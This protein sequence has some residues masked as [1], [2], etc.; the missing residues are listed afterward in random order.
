MYI[1]FSADVTVDE[2][3]ELLDELIVLEEL[4]E[5]EA[6][7]ELDELVVLEELVF[8][9]TNVLL[10][11]NWLSI[12]FNKSVAFKVLLEELLLEL[13]LEEL[14][15]E[16]LLE[17]LLSPSSSSSISISARGAPTLIFSERVLYPNDFTTI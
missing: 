16:L 13:L 14:L 1:R 3:E 8:P 4:E 9:D 2:L 12:E 7:E 15:L 6:L 10:L 11:V 17:E 5:L